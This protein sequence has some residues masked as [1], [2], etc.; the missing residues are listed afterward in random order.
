MISVPA[1][2]VAAESTVPIAAQTIFTVGGW[3]ITNSILMG[4]LVAA[5]LITSF[6]IMARRLSVR[7]K[8]SFAFTLESIAA[9]V[10]ASIT[11][12]FGGDERKARRFF[13]LFLAFFVFILCNNL[14]GLLPGMG[15]A[16]YV[17]SGGVMA[18]LL[19]PVTTDLNGT[20]ALAI[21]SIGTV[22]FI[23]IKERGL[24]K[25]IKH[26]YSIM[27]PWWNPVNF[28]I[29]TLEI[30]GELI[31]L[32][33]LA[34]RLFGV[35]YAG[36]VL[37]HV[38]S[39]ISGVMSPITTLPILLLEIFFSFIQAYL[40]IMLSA[41]YLSIGTAESSDHHSESPQPAVQPNK[42]QNGA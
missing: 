41:T 11:N 25:H 42:A 16:V 39:G 1:F 14:F 20:L 9:L 31:R 18:A 7:P 28:F 36:E 30:L 12:A 29:G 3:H 13:P 23:A 27:Q 15:G 26:Y 4:W 2:F 5:V 34:L 24:G 37:L 22:Q 38:I 10:I 32:M 6:V 35:I 40:F 19:R 33:T 8:D 21:V 17:D